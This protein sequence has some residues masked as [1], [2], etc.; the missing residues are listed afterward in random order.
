MKLNFQALLLQ[1][2]HPFRLATGMRTHTNAVLAKIEA[3]GKTGFGEAAMPPYYGENHDTARAFLNMAQAVVAQYRAPYHIGDIM[4]EIDA[5]A[6]GN[7]AA[8]AAV[9]IALHDLWGQLEGKPLSQLIGTEG[10]QMPLC[11]FT[12]GIDTPAVLREKMQDSTAFS[13]IKVKLG[14][15]DDRRII[16]TIRE[17]SDK[18]IYVD[19]NQGWQDREQALDLVHWLQAQG[20]E[21]VEQPFGKDQLDD[22]AWLTERS[23]LPVFADESFQRFADLQRIKG[24]FHGVNIKLMKCT[25]LNEGLQCLKAARNEGLKV[26]I[27][28][29]TETSCGIMAAAQLAPLCDHADLDGCWLIQNNPFELPGLLLGRV[30]RN[31]APGLGLSHLKN[32]LI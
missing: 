24:A 10:G 21:L 31:T 1:L 28:C 16:S 4:A 7:H 23:P 30:Q 9:D 32:I 26:M 8:K 29:M 19:A 13:V 15:S 22:S 27:G 17:L 12:L 25:G 5:L 11:S 20:V 2:K 14:T 3:E 6:A 18:P